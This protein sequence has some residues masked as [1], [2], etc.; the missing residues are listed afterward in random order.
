MLIP[1]QVA[2]AL[3]FSLFAY[4]LYVQVAKLWT[5]PSSN[6]TTIVYG[7]QQQQQETTTT[8][9][10]Q[11][12]SS[13]ARFDIFVG[14]DKFK[15][16]AA[17]FIAYDG[18]RERL[19]GHNYSI[20][21]RIRGTNM[22]GSDGY[23][24]D[25]GEVKAAVHTLCKR[26]NEHFIFPQ[27][28]SVLV[29]SAANTKESTSFRFTCKVDGSS[30]SLPMKDV[31]CLPIEHSSAEE[32]AEYVWF[33]LVTEFFK[34]ESL[35]SRG[36]L[37]MEIGVGEAP[38]QIAYFVCAIARAVNKTSFEEFKSPRRVGKPEPCLVPWSE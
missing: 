18:F 37:E 13:A 4:W 35:L 14:V 10:Q 11:E 26:M 33:T 15:F 19:H 3:L 36:V 34:P 30:F 16:S 20:S 22:L 29:S 23:V 7:K 21:V 6:N 12:H 8:T 17:H 1:A 2:D 24:V 32:L 25:F 38:N 28:S 31:L 5:V 9:S 27:N